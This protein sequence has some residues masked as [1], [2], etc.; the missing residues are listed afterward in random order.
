MTPGEEA[1]MERHFTYLQGL[2]ARGS[3][4]L[5]GPCLDGAFGIVILR[6]A[7]PDETQAMDEARSMMEG[8]PAIRAGIMQA[9]LHPFK[10]SLS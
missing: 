6:T 4:V 7:S 1:V 2:L 3:L 9:E 8:D 10:I 5:A